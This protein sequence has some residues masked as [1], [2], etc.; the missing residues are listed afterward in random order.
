MLDLV[1]E[2]N[3]EKRQSQAAA[4]RKFTEERSEQARTELLDAE[5]RLQ[6]FLQRNR[7]FGNDP[8]LTFERDRLGATQQD[9]DGHE[10][11][12]NYCAGPSFHV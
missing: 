10:T 7:D 11:R 2:F 6:R 5:N 9:A 1:S 12:G 4:E 3:L 8:S